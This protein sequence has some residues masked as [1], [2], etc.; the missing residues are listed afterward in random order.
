[1]LEQGKSVLEIRPFRKYK[2][3]HHS[4]A[5]NASYSKVMSLI[6]G[7][8]FLLGFIFLT[9]FFFF[10]LLFPA[11]L[12]LNGPPWSSF[13]PS[14]ICICR[15]I[16]LEICTSFLLSLF[17]FHIFYLLYL[18]QCSPFPLYLSAHISQNK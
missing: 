1:M 12:F 4:S 13:H 2:Y 9:F 14:L 17:F 10:Y 18:F 7:I 16:S 11:V 6:Y 3:L 5:A 8:N 15:Y